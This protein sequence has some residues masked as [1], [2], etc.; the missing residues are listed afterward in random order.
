MKPPS[1]I[2]KDGI[3]YML[4]NPTNFRRV[5]Y[6][7]KAFKIC[8]HGGRGRTRKKARKGRKKAKLA[9]V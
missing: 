4:D 3:Q 1:D 6:E 5:E 2:L 9:K 8:A 7:D